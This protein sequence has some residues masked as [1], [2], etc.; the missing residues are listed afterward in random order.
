MEFFMRD[1]NYCGSIPF[2]TIDKKCVDLK[3]DVDPLEKKG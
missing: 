2:D 3:E 1:G